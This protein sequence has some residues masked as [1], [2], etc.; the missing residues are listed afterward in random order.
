[1]RSGTVN[2]T[3]G[4]FTATTDS[5]SCNPNGSG[6][7]TTGVAIAIAQH[8][9]GKT[10][11]ATINVPAANLHA[12]KPVS[13]QNP[14]N[15]EFDNVAVASSVADNAVIPDGY[16]WKLNTTTNLYELAKAVATVTVGS[17]D[18]VAFDSLADAVAYANTNGGT[19]T[20]LEN[21]NVTAQIE[22]SGTFTLDLN[23]KTIEYTGQSALNSGVIMVLRGANLTINDSSNPDA[24]AIV[25]GDNAYAAVALTKAGETSTAN[26]TLTVNGGN[27][28]GYYYGITGNGSRHGTS[29]TVHGGN[30]TG[31]NGSAIYHPQDGTLTIDGGAFTGGETGI[32][33]R[34]GTVNITGGTFE[35]TASEYS[36]NPNGSG[37]TTVGAA[38][39]IAQ[40]TTNKQIDATINVPAANLTGVKPVSIQNP[41]NNEFNN[42]AVASSVTSN[43]K[44][45]AGYCWKQNT[46]TGL[47][48]LVK[49]VATINDTPYASLADAIAAAVDGDEI[50]M[51]ADSTENV[52]YDVTSPN[53]KNKTI[54]ISGAQALTS[55]SDTFGFYFGDYDGGNRPTTDKLTVSDITMVKS[56][57]NYTALF[58]GVT[59]DLTGVTIN[60]NGNT[61]LSYAN[62]AIGTL[63]NVTVT[64]TGNHSQTWRNTALALQ[65]IG[66]GPSEVTVKSGSYTSANGYAVYM[67]SSGGTLNIEGGTFSGE[68]M[69]QI[70]NNTYPGNQAI[71]NISGGTFTNCTLTESGGENAQIN[72]SGGYFDIDPTAYLANGYTVVTLDNTATGDDATA[73]AAGAIYKVVEAFTVTFNIGT[74]TYT[75]DPADLTQT[76]AYGDYAQSPDPDKLSFGNATFIGWQDSAYGEPIDLTTMPITSDMEFS[77]I[78]QLDEVEAELVGVNLLL[79]GAT[80]MQFHFKFPQGSTAHAVSMNLN[81]RVVKTLISNAGASTVAGAKVFAFPVYA[82]Q[83][84]TKILVNVLDEN[85]NPLSFSYQTSSGTVTT[86]EIEYAVTDYLRTKTVTQGTATL[87][88]LGSQMEEYADFAEYYFANRNASVSYGAVTMPTSEALSQYAPSAEG[89]GNTL[90]GTRLNLEEVTQIRL[91]FSDWN[92]SFAYRAPGGQW[93]DLTPSVVEGAMCVVI[94][95]INAQDLDTMWEIK[96]ESDGGT[97][98]V[99]YSALSY[100]RSSI[101]SSQSTASQSLKDYMAELY[102]YNRAAD[103]YFHN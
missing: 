39:A 96:A 3:G 32:E 12:I 82:K 26:A 46:T 43:A 72:I 85:D 79:Q 78:W 73:Y 64:N 57:G 19:L 9:T 2:I 55:T 100:V 23:G 75:G 77:I 99:Y 45:P 103:A 67:F 49:A 37:T 97:Y 5:Y 76:V 80:I 14:E 16:Y 61:G 47:Y 20:L 7:T 51:I 34:S 18:P 89:S 63:T 10:I 35:S 98:T 15:N 88:A 11:Q 69:A 28:T 22:V 90:T 86:T 13:V 54:A 102:Y 74:A 81:G 4:T 52:L 27:L 17:A 93:I 65:G 30:I 92:Q 60:S 84:K 36:C 33:V 83:L 48:E 87:Q 41:E 71:I 21:V 50:V 101:Y 42:V 94:P 56:G 6:T 59:A 29:I 24:G 91:Y 70:D 31:T 62:G 44:I 40:H 53:L 1:M 95:N 66:G 25:S 68:L 38:I 8:T 58:D